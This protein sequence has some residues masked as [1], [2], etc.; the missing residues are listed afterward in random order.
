MVVSLLGIR[1][2][3]EAN[4]PGHLQ[5]WEFACTEVQV[6]QT[7]P[8]WSRLGLVIFKS[9]CLWNST[10]SDFTCFK[11]NRNL[12]S[13]LFFPPEL[14][15]VRPHMLQTK[16]KCATGSNLTCFKMSRNWQSDVFFPLELNWVRPVDHHVFYH[17]RYWSM[18]SVI[19]LP[20]SSLILLLRS[21]FH[22]RGRRNGVS[23][24]NYVFQ[25]SLI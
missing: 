4:L 5:G 16:S 19:Y 20:S 21:P 23:L 14:Y 6:W 1:K 25:K 15:W 17:Y 12:K 22:V 9:F 13:D 18:T 10:E 2:W 8:D 24:F 11:I 7:I 3:R